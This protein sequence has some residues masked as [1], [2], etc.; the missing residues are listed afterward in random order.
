MRSHRTRESRG[1]RGWAPGAALLCLSL[2]IVGWLHLA[3]HG[4]TF[5]EPEV[6]PIASAPAGPV[7]SSPTRA[8]QQWAD[9]LTREVGR[10]RARCLTRQGYDEPERALAMRRE[11]IGSV[12]RA[13]LQV[14]LE[15]YGPATRPQARRFGFVGIDLV[16]DEGA[17]GVVAS[18]S[19][20][21]ETAARACS[22]WVAERA[23][24][25]SR[26][27]TS[28]ARLRDRIESEF[29]GDVTRAT[30]PALL[31]RA[32]CVTAHHPGLRPRWF[33]EA[34]SMTELL[35]RAGIAPGRVTAPATSSPEQTSIPRGVVRVLPPPV[36]RSYVPS[37]GEVELALDYVA[38]AESTGFA[39]TVETEVDRAL[40]RADTRYGAS[41][42]RLSDRLRDQLR[43]LSRP[44]GQGS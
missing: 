29:V 33:L 3:P 18:N 41:A 25:L 31:Q 7:E 39:R 35:D 8:V 30:T 34:E 22:A 1:W 27:Q 17:S 44:A 36:P 12:R 26:T 13:P 9:V 28:A 38:C 11:A 24:E 2:G 19:V 6:G 4:A 14:A 40:A 16:W 21:F 32:R 37:A 20:A 23:P 10:L 43:L 5:F 15:D 42:A